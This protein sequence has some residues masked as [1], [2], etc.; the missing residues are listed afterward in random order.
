MKKILISSAAIALAMASCTKFPD[1][2]PKT[3]VLNI[4][5]GVYFDLSKRA[6]GNNYV[7][8]T[9]THQISPAGVV[10]QVA[11]NLALGAVITNPSSGT[12]TTVTCTNQITGATMQANGNNLIFNGSVTFSS[13]N[14]ADETITLQRVI[15]SVD[16][17]GDGTA[18][19]HIL[20][21]ITITGSG[22][23]NISRGICMNSAGGFGGGCAGG[24][25]VGPVKSFPGISGAT[26]LMTYATTAA[27]GGIAGGITAGAHTL[28]VTLTGGSATVAGSVVVK[29]DSTT[30][31]SAENPAL[32]MNEGTT[33]FSATTS[34]T[35]GGPAVGS[36]ATDT[37]RTGLCFKNITKAAATVTADCTAARRTSSLGAI[38]ASWPTTSF[39][40]S[41]AGKYG[42]LASAP[43]VNTI[44]MPQ[45]TALTISAQ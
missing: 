12:G 10:S 15:S 14:N 44:Q 37:V 13:S 25:S 28:T 19:D 31:T 26:G 29:V 33:N 5:S 20:Y 45:F 9:P 27:L 41:T 42:A 3:A 7:C 2:D 40:V 23:V 8:T 24:G 17:E 1:A 22:S 16:L 36:A 38:L 4:D 18:N 21:Q 32:G 6:T 39:T 30:I 43:T 11:T 35:T 34:L